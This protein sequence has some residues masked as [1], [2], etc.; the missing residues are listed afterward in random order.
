MEFKTP[1]NKSKQDSINVIL[2]YGSIDDSSHKQ[3]VLT[4]VL[5]HLWGDEFEEKIKEYETTYGVEWDRG[6]A[7]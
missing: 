4:Q 6:I 1:E 2:T 7:P 3:W 5:K